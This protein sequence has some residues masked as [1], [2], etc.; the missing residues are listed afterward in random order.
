M[1]HPLCVTPGAL[2]GAK[3]HINDSSWRR[4]R[5]WAP[6]N[7]PANVYEMFSC[8]GT[9]RSLLAAINQ[10]G[11]VLP[12]CKLHDGPVDDD[13]LFEWATD[14]LAPQLNPYDSRTLP[15]S[16]L[17]LVSSPHPH[18]PPHYPPLSHFHSQQSP[19]IELVLTCPSVCACQDNAIIHH[20]PSFLQLLEQIGCLVYYLSP[21]SPDFSAIEPAFHQV[22][23]V[24]KR[25]RHA[26]MTHPNATLF[27]AMRQVTPDNMAGYF[28]NAGYPCDTQQ[29][30]EKEAVVA[31]AAVSAIVQAVA[32]AAAV[33]FTLAHSQ[34]VHVFLKSSN[35]L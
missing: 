35:I 21:Y 8:D 12:A 5:G 20:Q 28:R 18:T 14:Y 29:E 10:D 25:N 13:V 33:S 31:A 32:A 19:E 1:I 6:I 4:R 17:I 23:A 24:L 3:S 9:S 30:K 7:K 2:G 22:K 27:T 16:I 26:C 34:G 11:F 15:N